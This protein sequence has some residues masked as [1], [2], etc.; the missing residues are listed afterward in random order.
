MM[1][2][3]PAQAQRRIDRPLVLTSLAE[4]HTTWGEVAWNRGDYRSAVRSWQVAARYYLQAE[5]EGGATQ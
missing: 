2:I 5:R 3:T 1:T 4:I